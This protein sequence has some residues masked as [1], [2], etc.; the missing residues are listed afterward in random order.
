MAMQLPHDKQQKRHS[1]V[2]PLR[3]IEHP[4]AFGA[5]LE[6]I[7]NRVRLSRQE[8][9]NALPQYFEEHNVTFPMDDPGNMYYK[10]EKG[11]AVQFEELIP[12]YA[13]LI[14][15]GIKQSAEERHT[16][17]RLARLKLETLRRKRPKLRSDS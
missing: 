4:N 7:R 16:F 17:V 5:H 1:K 13:A 9:A 10:V 15:C 12:L 6:Y 8:V 2:T 11:R 14:G 3:A